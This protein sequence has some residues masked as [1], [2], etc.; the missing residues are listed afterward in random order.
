MNPRAT[1]TDRSSQFESTKRNFSGYISNELKLFGVLKTIVGL[2]ME[3]FDLFY[4]GQNSSGDNFNNQNVINKL[5]LFPTGNFIYQISENSNLR[6]SFTRTTAR[7]SFKEA[8]IAQIFDPLSNMTFVGNIDLKPTYIQNYDV[9][10]EFFGEFSQMMAVS[11]FYKIFQ[12]P[13]EMTYYESAPTNFTPN[14]F[15]SANV[16]GIE[17]EIRKNLQFVSERLKDLSFNINMSIIESRLTFSESEKA[18]RESSKRTGET[19]GDF[20][21]LQG[22]APY[23]INSGI[24]YSNPETGIQTGLFY[25][26][27]GKT[28]EIVGDGFRPDVFRIPFHSLN[29]NF[30]KT[31]G[32]ERKST[33]NIRANNLLGDVKE[34]MVESYGTEALNF[35]LRNPGRIF[36]LGF[37]YRF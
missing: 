12:D 6:T 24:S 18:R 16:G 25:N 35:R 11:F 1:I 29:F 32:K 14:N 37:K 3:K 30:N 15:G 26:V 7:P 23:L 20:R 9:R 31:F 33:I 8:S 5:D 2:R 34:S 22:Q 21:T 4:T 13:I 27:Q 19:V 10:Y 36:S 17:F 28:L